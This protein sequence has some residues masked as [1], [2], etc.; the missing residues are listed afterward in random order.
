[1]GFSRQEYWSGLPFPPPGDLPKPETEPALAGRFFTTESPGK[2]LH[3][4]WGCQN[5]NSKITL[6]TRYIF[7]SPHGSKEEYFFNLKLILILCLNIKFTWSFLAVVARREMQ[8]ITWFK[9]KM[10]YMDLSKQIFISQCEVLEIRDKG[11]RW[12]KCHNYSFS[13]Y[14]VIHTDLHIHNYR[15]KT[16]VYITIE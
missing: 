15:H 6:Q 2:P 7:T 16:Y 3:V 10:N 11:S 9:Y 8:Q 1:M 4:Q 5:R 12:I 14:I 13:C